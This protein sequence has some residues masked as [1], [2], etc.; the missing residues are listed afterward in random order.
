MIDTDKLL[1]L[2]DEL[3]ILMPKSGRAKLVRRAA[4]E[5]IN[6]RVQLG[7]AKTALMLGS[8]IIDHLTKERDEAKQDAEHWRD[9]YFDQLRETKKWANAAAEYIG[10][11]IEAE[12]N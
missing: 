11:C 6:L 5:I 2:V 4:D 9:A 10:R 8:G 7:I 1:K 3:K 12:S